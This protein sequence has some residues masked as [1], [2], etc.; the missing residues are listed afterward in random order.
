MNPE[1]RRCWNCGNVA[2]H[3]DNVSPP[4]LCKKC[5]SQDTRLTRKH[6]IPKSITDGERHECFFCGALNTNRFGDKWICPHCEH[7]AA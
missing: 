7:D 1:E 6:S 3:D 2:M 5:G 4:V